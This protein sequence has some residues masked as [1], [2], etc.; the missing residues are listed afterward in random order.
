MRRVLMDGVHTG[1]SANAHYHCDADGHDDWVQSRTVAPID[2]GT[3]DIDGIVVED[4]EMRGLAHAAGV[5]LGLPEALIR[6]ISIRRLKIVSARSRRRCDRAHHGRPHQADA[7]RND[8]HRTGGDRLR[9][10]SAALPQLRFP[11][12]AR[13]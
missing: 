11:L 5:F 9:R 2:A 6:N 8:P 10:T 1:L 12:S 13:V 7:A 3:P 4:V